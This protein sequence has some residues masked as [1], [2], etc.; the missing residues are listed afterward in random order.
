MRRNLQVK[1]ALESLPLFFASLA[2]FISCLGLFSLASF[3]AEQRTKEIGIRKVMGATLMNIWRMLSKE[4]VL[5]VIIACSLSIPPAYY[6][7]DEW[8]QKY[9][10]RIELSVWTFF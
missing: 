1:N 7:M 6:L 2:I 4:F 9:Q 8:L 10:Y 3:V 5:L